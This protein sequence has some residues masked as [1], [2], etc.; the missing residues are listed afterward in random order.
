MENRKG[1]KIVFYISSLAKGGAQRV[2]INLT[3]A[4]LDKGYQVCLVTTSQA[5]N[6]YELPQKAT[7]IISD[8]EEKEISKNR[9]KNLKNRFLK[10]RNIWK[11]EQPD[12]IVSFIGKNNFMAILT[13]LGLRIPVAVSV[14]GEPAEEYY[15]TSMRILAKTL[16]GAASGIIL[17]TPDAKEF[18]PKRIQAKAVILPNPINPVFI[19]NDSKKEREKILVSVGRIDRNKNQKLIIDAFLNIAEKIPDYHLVLYGEGEERKNLIDYIEGS[20]YYDRISLPGEITDVKERIKKAKVFILSSNSEGMPN[21]LME[22]L[23]LG[24]PC[25]S[26]DCPCG[27]PRMLLEGKENGILVPVGEVE[28]MSQAI[29]KILQNEELWEKYS[30][31]AR[32]IVEELHPDRVNKQW[33]KYLESLIK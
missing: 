4:F 10:L 26:T 3:K 13:S 24:I 1:K 5:E 28:A 9:I 16:M 29:K 32:N 33:E 17:Q 23:A 11:E 8:L 15:N 19:E 20:R 12:I 14:R 22:A 2:I 31:N 21:A 7:R 30:K 25:I 6:E 27:G 18:F